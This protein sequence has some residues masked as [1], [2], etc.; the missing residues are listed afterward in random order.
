MGKVLRFAPDGCD[1]GPC[2]EWAGD[3][4]LAVVS[5]CL[6]DRQE[7]LSHLTGDFASAFLRVEH[8]RRARPFRR[9]E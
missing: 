5:S 7:Y 9:Q 1:D 8:A 6:G 2:D 3:I 4:A